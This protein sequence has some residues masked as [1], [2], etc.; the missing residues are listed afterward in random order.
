MAGLDASQIAALL[1]KTRQKGRYIEVLNEFIESGEM[2][3]SVKQ[4]WP[5]F[6][7]KKEATL[8][9]GFDSAK[10]H[11]DAAEG[12]DQIKV[13]NN[14]GDTFLINLATAS[15]ELGELATAGAA[16]E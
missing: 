2:G 12:A 9:Q 5:E 11:K 6:A 4:T 16:S 8:K 14:E 3:V 15:E 13:V 1:G 10:D 7:E